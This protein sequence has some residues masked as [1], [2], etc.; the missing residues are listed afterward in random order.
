MKRALSLSLVS[1][2]VVL[3]PPFVGS[4]ACSGGSE[5]P[6]GGDDAPLGYPDGPEEG[7]SSCPPTVVSGHE[8][9]PIA[10]SKAYC[11]AECGEGGTG[12]CYCVKDPMTS[13]GVWK[14]E[15]VNCGP[16]CAPDSDACAL[17]GSTFADV[18]PV[19]DSFVPPDTGSET[20]GG[21]AGEAVDA[22]PDAPK[23]DS[24]VTDAPAKG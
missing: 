23:V 12:G 7:P 1:L 14:C 22:P 2:A 4:A 8:C 16:T 9:E 15:M 10:P 11:A 20:S 24:T 17:E 5:T 3:L 19:P 13:R 6:D 18:G 21:D